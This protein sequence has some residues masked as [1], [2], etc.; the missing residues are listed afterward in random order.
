M[1]P[2]C[3]TCLDNACCN[4]GAACANDNSCVGCLVANPPASCAND[5]AFNNLNA[6]LGSSCAGPCG[7]SSSSGAPTTC[8]EADGKVGCCYNNVNYYCTS[9]TATTV[10]HT[11]CSAGES[12][13]WSA[14]NN[15][16]ACGPNAGADPT[17][18]YPIDCP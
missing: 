14:A 1:I 16:Y 7:G 18:T 17:G 6:C 2:A 3:N 4:E 15:Y 11:T 5:A 9:N 10:K 13:G 8:S 12:C